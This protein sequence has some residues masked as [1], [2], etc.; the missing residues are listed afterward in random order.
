MGIEAEVFLKLCAY[1]LSEWPCCRTNNM[2][3]ESSIQCCKTAEK[4]DVA[5]K[6]RH[7]TY[8]NLWAY[9]GITLNTPNHTYVVR[10]IQNFFKIVN[11][12]QLITEI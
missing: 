9:I 11:Y 7:V 4:P 5:G 6:T 2:T 3:G 12:W 1:Q 8:F 10:C